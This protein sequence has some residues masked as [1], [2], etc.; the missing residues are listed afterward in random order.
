MKNTPRLRMIALLIPLLLLGG[1]GWITNRAVTQQRELRVLRQRLVERTTLSTAN[2]PTAD[3]APSERP[4]P[5]LLRARAEVAELVQQ[6]ARRTD[7]HAADREVTYASGTDGS[8]LDRLMKG[9][10]PS[11]FPDFKAA[12]QI[13]N[14]GFDTADHALESFWWHFA[15]PDRMGNDSVTNLWWSPPTNPPTGFH[16]EIFLGMGVGGLTG[17]RVTRREEI[18]SDEVLFHLHREEGRS[19]VEEQ[20]RFIRD[21]NRWVRKPSVKLVPDQP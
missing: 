21:G 19:V 4:S 1:L 17:Y 2:A 20:A 12:D 13:Q 18:S 14:R 15:G 11:E 16:Y 7:V 6:A 10:R 5:E 8:E 9:R 3:P